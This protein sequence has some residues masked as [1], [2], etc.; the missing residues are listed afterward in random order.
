MKRKT[1][2]VMAIAIITALGVYCLN[3][4]LSKVSPCTKLY[5][6]DEIEIIRRYCKQTSEKEVERRVTVNDRKKINAL[7]DSIVLKVPLEHGLLWEPSI[8]IV[9]KKRGVEIA[10]M[11]LDE[12]G[13]G[14]TDC[15]FQILGAS[16]LTDQ[17]SYLKV[18]EWIHQNDKA[19][20]LINE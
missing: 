18:I 11:L 1:I 16:Y 13:A 4:W 2:V 10:R 20:N 12:G 6:S 8:S 19:Y 3:H 5:D 14:S 17:D 15:L 9:W 7:N